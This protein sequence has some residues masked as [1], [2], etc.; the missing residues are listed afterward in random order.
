VIDG[1]EQLPQI[2]LEMSLEHAQVGGRGLEALPCVRS[3]LVR[4]L[5]TV[6]QVDVL[7]GNSSSGVCGYSRHELPGVLRWSS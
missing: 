3:I 5:S 7:S 6:S 2:N 1:N 4:A